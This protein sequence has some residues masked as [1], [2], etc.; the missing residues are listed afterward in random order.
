MLAV[1]G[2]LLAGVMVVVS[3]DARRWLV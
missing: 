1:V 3:P 2:L